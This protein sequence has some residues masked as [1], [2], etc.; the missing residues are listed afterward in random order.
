MRPRRPAW[1]AF[2]PA[3]LGA[4]LVLI[5]TGVGVAAAIGITGLLLAVITPGFEMLEARRVAQHVDRTRA[6]LADHR[7][8][9][10]N[11]VRDHGDRTGG[12]DHMAAPGRAF[13]A[14][15]FSALAMNDLGVQGMAHVAPGGRV[16]IARWRGVGRRGRDRDVLGAA[17]LRDRIATLDLPR[18]LGDRRSASWFAEVDGHLAAIGAAVIR[19]S[20]GLGAPRG[21]VI[22]ARI[23]T[24]RGL[25]DALQV[26]AAIDRA[27]PGPLA[28]PTRTSMV[29][30]VPIPGVD[31]RPVGAARF[32]VPRDVSLLGRRVLLLAVAGSTLLLLAVLMV[33]RRAIDRLV[34]QPL[35]RVERHMQ[36]VRA[37][38]SLEILPGDARPDEI[39]SL[40]RSFNAMLSQL[41]A[42]REQIEGQ[43]F[44]LG[45]SESAVA[46]MHN[47]R[48]ALSPVSTILSRGVAEAPPIDR[49]VLDRAV[50]E[51][52]RDE[53]DGARRRKLA[54]FLAA[55]I[56]ADA[57][58]R[59]RQRRELQIGR[60]AMA[61]VL[62]I[63]GEQQAHAHERPAL[64]PCDV[65]EIVARNAAIARY[66]P[67]VSIGFSFPGD[68]HP[69]LAN[70]VILS[71]VVGNLLGNAAEAIAAT[72]RDH[73][74]IAVT[75]VE[76]GETTEVRI[77][78]DGEGF[79]PGIA[80]ALFQR[81]F[82]TR[83]HKSGGLG[84]HWCANSMTA[85]EGGLS[86][87]SE[88]PGRGSVAVL[89][90]RSA[91]EPV[92]AEARFAVRSPPRPAPT[93]SARAA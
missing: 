2:A 49:A 23:L 36:H 22:M 53:A 41:N 51:L 86:L 34:L 59:D 93:G 13:E 16:L 92:I 74:S 10:E 65:S 71:Q 75:V 62:E 63:I 82:S 6:A 42:L 79:A 8:G 52:A 87:L 91:D 14:E 90:L 55:S 38:G 67:G 21:H 40:G 35:G 4:K 61:H 30:A 37:S 19:R 39:G 81:G 58:A 15:S 48:N 78:D 69:V 68:R 27:A 28:A 54:A 32:G 12:Y 33:L 77:R 18:I 7:A 11:A 64:E 57:R 43:S 1:K 26:S 66:A 9:V 73:G 85:M 70:R 83:A 80:A 24:S 76:A 50:G 5:L 72:G 47:V 17:R 60:E 3:S 89:T 45:R 25:S 20:D 44:A 84:L 56:D 31:G 88:G 46:V 29:I